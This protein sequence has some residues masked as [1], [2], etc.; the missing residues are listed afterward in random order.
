MWYDVHG[1]ILVEKMANLVNRELFAKIFFTNIFRDTPKMYLVY[2]L[3]LYSLRISL[4]IA[5]TF[6]VCQKFPHFPAN[7]QIDTPKSI[8][9]T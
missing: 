4:L 7:V 3:T 8:S 5:F 9:L 2:T 1:K 6:M